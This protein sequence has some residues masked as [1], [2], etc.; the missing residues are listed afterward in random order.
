M[1]YNITTQHDGMVQHD[2]EWDNMAYITAQ[3]YG[4]SPRGIE[5]DCDANPL[6]SSVGD[7]RL[8]YVKR[9]GRVIITSLTTLVLYICL[10]IW[11]SLSLLHLMT[12][13]SFSGAPTSRQLKLTSRVCACDAKGVW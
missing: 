7:K 13:R 1:A 3:H 4:M 5:W 8:S 9:R 6:A 11:E 12:S 10:P 2:M